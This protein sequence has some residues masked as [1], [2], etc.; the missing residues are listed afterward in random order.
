MARPMDNAWN[1]RLLSKTLSIH[2]TAFNLVLIESYIYHWIQKLLFYSDRWTFKFILTNDQVFRANLAHCLCTL[3]IQLKL[4]A[5]SDKLMKWSMYLQLVGWICGTDRCWCVHILPLYNTCRPE[6][7]T[8]HQT[9]DPEIVKYCYIM[10][11]IPLNCSTPLFLGARYMLF[12][13]HFIFFI[14][15]S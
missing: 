6:S 5:I 15:R 8:L 4:L 14:E 12:H 11:R 1:Y 7:I 10:F 2:P 3:K 9:L 13:T